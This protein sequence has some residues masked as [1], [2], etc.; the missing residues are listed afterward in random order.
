LRSDGSIRLNRKIGGAELAEKFARGVVREAEI[1]VD[2]FLIEHGSA[3]KTPHLLFFDRIAW[4]RQNVAA[5]GKDSAGNLPIERGEK[6]DRTFV[7]G[8]NGVA[9]AQLDVIG[10]SDAID[11]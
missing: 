3:E 1:T 6:G 2:E 7:K 5:P 9:A 10:G 8:E 4:G 11:I